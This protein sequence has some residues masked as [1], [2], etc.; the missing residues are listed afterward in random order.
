M[1]NANYDNFLWISDL[2]NNI[3][4]RVVTI[5][6]D[7]DKRDSQRNV[8]TLGISTMVQGGDNSKPQG[9]TDVQGIR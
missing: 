1:V 7:V 8:E 4:I 2:I 3:A 6:P 9:T 5:D